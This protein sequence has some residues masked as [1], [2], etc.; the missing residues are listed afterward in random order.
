MKIL[1]F[2]L[3]LTL[4]FQGLC[5]SEKIPLLEDA[6]D[7]I[8]YRIDM[9]NSS[10]QML[11]GLLPRIQTIIYSNP[12]KACDLICNAMKVLINAEECLYNGRDPAYLEYQITESN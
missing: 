2:V 9:A 5:F 8:E 3:A 4:L 1:S 11:H 6:I 7:N 12:D 10:L